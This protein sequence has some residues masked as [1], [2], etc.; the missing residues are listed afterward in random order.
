M[1]NFGKVKIR[2]K[3]CRREQIDVSAALK[4]VAGATDECRM[5]WLLAVETANDGGEAGTKAVE[6]RQL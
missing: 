3:R 6:L 2:E 1:S 5:I 4:S